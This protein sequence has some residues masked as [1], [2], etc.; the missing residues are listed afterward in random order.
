[1]LLGFIIQQELKEMIYSS[2]KNSVEVN[3][4]CLWNKFGS[5]NS[6][7]LWLRPGIGVVEWVFVEDLRSRRD[8]GEYE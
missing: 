7:K 5:F 1:M 6:F 4:G 2:L 8:I 3:K